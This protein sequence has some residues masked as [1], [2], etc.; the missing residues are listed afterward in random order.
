VVDP[1]YVNNIPGLDQ[2]DNADLM[3]IFTRFRALPDEQME[4]I[5]KYLESGKPIIG[6]R[7]ATHAFNFQ[8]S[9]SN[10]FNYGNYYSSDDDWDGGF[11]R[12]ILGENWVAHHGHHGEQS[13]R[14]VIADA[15]T[16]HPILNGIDSGIWGPTDVY[17]VRLPMQE[18][19]T[20][21]L[22]GK[23]VDRVNPRDEN[24]P[25]LGLRPTDTAA[26]PPATRKN[27]AGEEVI[28]DLNDPMM[29]IAWV[30]SYQLENG[31]QG[32]VFASTIGASVDLLSEEVR[33]MYVN[34][35][36]HLLKMPVPAKSDVS[37]VGEY[38][39]SRFAF[40]DDAYWDS[41][42]LIIEEMK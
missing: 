28:V 32:Q 37:I 29:P 3:V 6:I 18:G 15:M 31:D 30:K 16:D 41:Q 12:R 20:P 36:Y 4:H 24:D 38:S 27:P 14:G 1:N 5:E 26:P 13:T 2:L 34:A 21:L 33:R 19:V 42:H 35:V 7:T 25:M 17:A 11:G 10:Y 22:L 23:T 9:T 39:P 40:Q 8:D